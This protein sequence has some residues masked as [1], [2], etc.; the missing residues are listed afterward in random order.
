MVPSFFVVGWAEGLSQ[1]A[2]FALPL[3]EAED[4]ALAHGALNV[5]DDGT[6]RVVQEFHA[7]LRNVMG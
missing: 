2:R 4:V 7:H 5:A 3:E 6:G 1:T